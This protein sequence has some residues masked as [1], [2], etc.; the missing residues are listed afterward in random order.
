[1]YCAPGGGP[2]DPA[3]KN[4]RPTARAPQPQRPRRRA[5]A[6]QVHSAAQLHISG[7]GDPDIKEVIGRAGFAERGEAE[8]E[9][10][11]STGDQPESHHTP[12]PAASTG[13]GLRSKSAQG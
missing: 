11:E 2:T 10:G 6:R 7:I 4:Q 1:M 5:I 9:H 8:V 13:R 3:V 12:G